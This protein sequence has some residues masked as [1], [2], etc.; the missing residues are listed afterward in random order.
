MVVGKRSSASAGGRWPLI[1]T[2]AATALLLGLSIPSSSISAQASG[3]RAPLAQRIVHY[4]AS[5]LRQSLGSHDGAGSLSLSGLL[6]PESIDAPLAFVHR[7]YVG[8]RSSIGHHFHNR[9]EEMFVIFEGEAQFTIDG[10]TS[11]IKGPAAVPVRMG[12]SHAIYN[13]S[14]Q[15]LNWMNINIPLGPGSSAFN[16]GDDRVGVPL[17]PKP[18]FMNTRFDPALLQP[19][20]GLRGGRGTVRYRRAFDGAVFSTSWSYVDHVVAPPGASIGPQ[21][22]GGLAEIYYVFG[23]SG[24]VTVDGET[25][26]IKA[27]DILPINTG[28]TRSF[29]ASGAQPLEMLIVGIAKDLSSKEAFLAIPRPA[30]PAPARR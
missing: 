23:G 28:Q 26:P 16:L 18:V 24:T 21:T 19:V 4:D 29:A 1:R 13:P 14:G 22:P 6:G 10:R 15:P 8:P 9:A 2:A 25:A 11:V 5:N 12:H 27:H 30:R 3:A 7:G 17:D 20:E